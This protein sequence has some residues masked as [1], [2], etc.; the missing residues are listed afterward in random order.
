MTKLIL[1]LLIIAVS[2]IFVFQSKWFIDEEKTQEL[3]NDLALELV[4]NKL[5]N[6]ECISKGVDELYRSC[7]INLEEMKEKNVLLITVI[8]EGFF[9]D[10]VRGSRLR[11]KATF[12]NNEW[13]TEGEAIED[14]QCWPGRG[15][16]NFSAELCI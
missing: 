15:H 6:G 1:V 12:K 2:I 4:R 8:Y 5:I 3:T 11:I 10:S 9:D 13:V 16:E 14:F 7:V